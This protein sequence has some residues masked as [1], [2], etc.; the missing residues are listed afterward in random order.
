MLGPFKASTLIV[1][2]GYMRFG[3]MIYGELRKVETGLP[4]NCCV[5]S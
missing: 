2:K 5:Y 4:A 1:G 3:R